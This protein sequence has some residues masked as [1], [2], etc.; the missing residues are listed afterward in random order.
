MGQFPLIPPNHCNFSVDLSGGVGYVPCQV[1]DLRPF[2]Y[3]VSQEHWLC[4]RHV[5]NVKLNK[6]KQK[7]AL[8]LTFYTYKVT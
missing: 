4:V 8:E 2:T 1:F 5:N 6:M 7:N 3:T